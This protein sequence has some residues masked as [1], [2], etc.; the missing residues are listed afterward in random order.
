MLV[1]L[2]RPDETHF[3]TIDENNLLQI[4]YARGKNQVWSRQ[5]GSLAYL[6]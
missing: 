2:I 1:A 5:V 6:S 3:A 4:F